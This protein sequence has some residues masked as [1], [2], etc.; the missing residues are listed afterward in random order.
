MRCLVLGHSGTAG[1]GVD[2]PT[3]SW[4][5]LFEHLLK[6]S[7]AKDWAVSAVALFPVGARAIEYAVK[8]VQQ[9]QPDLVVLSLNAYPCV[10][11]V[12]SA[13]VRHRF[14]SWAER[15][16]LGL[17]GGLGTQVHEGRGSWSAID[18]VGRRWAR[19]LLGTRTVASVAEVGGVYAEILRRL[20]R[21]E[22]IQVV[23]LAEALFGANV[24]RR[25]PDL[26]Q[27]VRDMHSL[28]R[29]TAQDHRF[30]WFDASE[31]LVPDGRGAFWHDD[32][33]H[34]SLRGNSRYA[35]MLMA[36]L[37]AKLP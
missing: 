16:Y 18:K 23:V 24:R 25:V 10:V 37:A 31:W 22:G 14:G 20:A 12:V 32:D 5:A 29:P 4:P 26:E 7:V 21:L 33:V 15:L 36:S 27:R 19:R 3:Q 34:L 35:E 13:S 6:G 28:V 1:F 11:P 2:S 17:E 30:L 9:V 8:R